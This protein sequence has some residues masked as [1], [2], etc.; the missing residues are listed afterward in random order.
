MSDIIRD[1]TEITRAG[2]QYRSDSFA[3]MGLKA[4]HASYLQEICAEPGISQ[5][6]LASRICINKS[7]V[8][9]QAAVLEEGGFITRVSCQNDKRV[10]RLY[11]TEKSLALLPQIQKIM[12]DWENCLTQGLSEDEKE[13]L[14]T[15]LERMKLRASAWM[16]SH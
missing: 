15:L 10:M 9:R 12:D 14:V 4:C 11:P 1:I 5:D 8:A 2:T 3:P 16:D 6:R 7:N 13:I